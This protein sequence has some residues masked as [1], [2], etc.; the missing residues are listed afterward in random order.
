MSNENPLGN[1]GKAN[2]DTWARKRDAEAIDALKKK[3]QGGDKSDAAPATGKPGEKG[4]SKPVA[5]SK[6]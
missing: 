3:G 2:E 1:R 6:S 5:K 4:K